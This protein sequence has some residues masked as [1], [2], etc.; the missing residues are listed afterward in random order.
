MSNTED[1]SLSG[2]SY[3]YDHVS[4]GYGPGAGLNYIQNVIVKATSNVFRISGSERSDVDN[5]DSKSDIL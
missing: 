2:A 5:D 3:N 4:T 1:A